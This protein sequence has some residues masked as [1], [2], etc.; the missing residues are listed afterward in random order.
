M[1]VVLGIVVAVAT[2]DE[3]EGAAAAPASEQAAPVESTPAAAEAAPAEEL[4]AVTLE[5]LALFAE[6]YAFKDDPTFHS[7]GFV[8]G[9]PYFSWVEQQ[10]SIAENEGVLPLQQIGYLSGDVWFLAMEYM[11]H[12]GGATKDMREMERISLPILNRRF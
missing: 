1:F 5:V 2:D 12:A 9:G 7:V 6:L 3:T 8:V 10:D 11:R 4:S